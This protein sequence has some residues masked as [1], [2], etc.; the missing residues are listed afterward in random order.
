MEA[1]FAAA[2]KGLSR[3]L[4]KKEQGLLAFLLDHPGLRHK[5]STICCIVENL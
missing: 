5:F 2:G 1:Q 4:R 3:S